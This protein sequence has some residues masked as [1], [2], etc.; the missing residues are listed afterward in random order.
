MQQ[1]EPLALMARRF[2]PH[3]LF[4]MAPQLNIDR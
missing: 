1:T 3:H 4:D 2:T